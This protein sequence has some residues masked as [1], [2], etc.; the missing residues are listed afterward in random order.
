LLLLLL[1]TAIGLIP[2]GSGYFTCIHVYFFRNLRARHAVVTGTDWPRTNN[3][4]VYKMLT[5]DPTSFG[6]TS[7]VSDHSSNYCWKA[8]KPLDSQAESTHYMYA[9]II[10]IIFYAVICNGLQIFFALILWFLRTAF[11]PQKCRITSIHFPKS[12]GW[13]A[14]SRDQNAGRSHGIKGGRVQIFG[15]NLNNSKF[16]SGRN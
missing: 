15:N 14:M 2:G 11:T 6:L 10:C 9:Y 4:N 3:V 12:V 1:L 7:I 5:Y 16:Y 13:L 8:T